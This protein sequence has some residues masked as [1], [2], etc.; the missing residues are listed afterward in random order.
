MNNNVIKDFADKM[1]L[2]APHLALEPIRITKNSWRVRDT[3]RCGNKWVQ[4]EIK[5]IE[6]G[7]VEDF[8]KES[9]LGRI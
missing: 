5:F 8:N 1:A 2:I 9:K 6:S 3:V 4:C 7:R